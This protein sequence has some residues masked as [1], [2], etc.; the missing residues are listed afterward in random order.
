MTTESTAY[1]SLRAQMEKRLAGLESPDRERRQRLYES[2]RGVL[3]AKYPQHLHIFEN[4]ILDL[5]ATFAPDE[6]RVAAE[7]AYASFE[8]A[9]GAEPVAEKVSQRRSSA[10]PPMIA[11][12]GAGAVAVVAIGL[13]MFLTS[14]PSEAEVADFDAGIEGYSS[15][16]FPLEQIAEER[17]NYQVDLVDGDQVLRARG[18]FPLYR[19]DE[20]EVDL[21]KSYR[22]RYKLRVV[23][24][25]PSVG[26]ATTYVGVAT[27]NA[28]GQLETDPPGAHRYA[29]LNGRV[30]KAADGWVEGEG[31]VSG[32]GN[33]SSTQFRTTTR[34]IRP[35]ALLNYQSPGA[36]TEIAYLKFEPIE[37]RSN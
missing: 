35:L 15:K 12:V 3:A 10:F 16:A 34:S 25:D 5:E 22:L 8:P 32:A 6:D 20:V 4:V 21:T 7:P 2:A 24:D 13:W 1:N 26:G 28:N 18:A 19:M 9:P 27:Y 33:D 11:A 29:G 37:P 31:I 23:Q 30:I 36:T 17:P 14:A